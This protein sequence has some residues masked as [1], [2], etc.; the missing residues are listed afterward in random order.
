MKTVCL[1]ISTEGSADFSI[2]KLHNLDE[3]TGKILWI[4]QSRK[5]YSELSSLLLSRDTEN[6]KRVNGF[7]L[8]V[9][10]SVV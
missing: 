3:A 2:Q 6:E 1:C 10:P 7:W 4:V 8:K 5:D 9:C